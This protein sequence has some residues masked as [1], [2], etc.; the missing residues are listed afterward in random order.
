MT[1]QATFTDTDLFVVG[2]VFASA[3]QPTVRMVVTER[4]KTDKG[5][6]YAGYLTI[7]GERVAGFSNFDLHGDPDWLL[8]SEPCDCGDCAQ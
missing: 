6:K 2:S 4:T 7:E 1:A 3:I 5:Y 8:E